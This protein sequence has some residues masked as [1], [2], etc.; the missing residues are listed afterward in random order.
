MNL[1]AG[2]PMIEG[3]SFWRC[4]RSPREGFQARAQGHPGL[5]GSLSEMLL[6]RTPLTIAEGLLASWSLSRLYASLQTP[7]S[8]L[9]RSLMPFLPPGI[10]A[11]DLPYLLRELP[12]FP[13]LSRLLPWIL[14]FSPLYVLSLWLHNACWD[15]GCLWLLQGTERKGSFRKTLVAEC[16]VLSVG[17]L[18]ALAGLLAY[19]P[20]A[21]LLLAPLTGLVGAYFWILRGFSL[22]AFHGCPLWKGV[23]ATL[24]HGV[25][26]IAGSLLFF[27]LCLLLLV[28]VA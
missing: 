9:W 16:E 12:D 17:S 26:L 3:R 24:L 23:T 22:A 5:L 8:P 7:E 25:L 4:I 19:L 18:G 13:E 10:E 15:H 1:P 21:G 11:A 14:L 27:L 28:P 6:W 2:P 20:A